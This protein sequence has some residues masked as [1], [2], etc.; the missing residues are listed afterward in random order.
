MR[1]RRASI[2]R[3]LSSFLPRSNSLSPSYSR[4]STP[5]KTRPAQSSRSIFTVSNVLT[6]PKNQTKGPIKAFSLSKHDHIQLNDPP[7]LPLAIP[8]KPK[9]RGS[10]F[11]NITESFRSREGSKKDSQEVV[12]FD[13]S[14]PSPGFFLS[15]SLFLLFFPFLPLIAYC[16]IIIHNISRFKISRFHTDFSRI[17][18]NKLQLPCNRSSI[19]VFGCP[20]RTFCYRGS[21]PF[22]RKRRSKEP[23]SKECMLVFPLSFIYYYYF[24]HPPQSMPSIEDI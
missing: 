16:N 19:R 3:A 21:L 14:P 18:S 20:Q 10:A 12:G 15:L 24:L 9:R 4:N 22:S 23:P 7:P 5:P 17:S 1:N 2:Q 11:D 6:L 8:Q 13:I